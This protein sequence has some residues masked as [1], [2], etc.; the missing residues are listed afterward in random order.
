M[1]ESTMLRL[2]FVLVL[3]LAFAGCVQGTAPAPAA[4]APAATEAPAME[5]GGALV[6]WDQFYR[7]VESD[8]METLNAEF[9]ADHAG[10]TIDRDAKVL[11]DLTT[12]VQLALSEEDG[13]DVSQVNQGRGNM[14]PLVQGDLLLPVDEYADQYGWG[15]RLSESIQRRNRFTADGQ[16]FGEGNLYGVSPT[17]E[18]VGVYYN[19]D[20]F[21]EYGWSIPATF[22]EFQQLLADIAATGET[23]IAFGNLDGWPGI[24][25]FS[26]VEHVF[27]DPEWVDN[28]VY[29]LNDVSF[30]TDVNIQAAEIM[31]EWV[32]SGYFT[33]GF[34][35]IGYDDTVALF[36]SGDGVLMITGSWLSGELAD[37]D[38][39]FGFF[40]MPQETADAQQLA[41]GGVGIPFAIRRTTD[42]ADLAA[43][44]LDWM[45]S[46]RA[47]ELWAE[48]DFVPAMPLPEGAA[49]EEGSML[50]DT[51]A[52]WNRINADNGVGHYL[53]WATP[54]MYDTLVSELQKLFAA[55][56]SPE[57]FVANV[58]AD[59][60]EFLASQ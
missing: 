10:V 28:F 40:L 58:Q 16:T 48:A 51:I 49:V 1:R 25:E 27:A 3:A 23:P 18:V 5:E 19:Q 42:Q 12:T 22:D 36:K 4:E 24:H 57:E 17:A 54:T 38:F 2:T 9:E 35:G 21:E 20:K 34:E 56:T 43:E 8:V 41:V 7:G 15:E 55:Q 13:P 60:A 6:V 44:Y 53:D 50:A 46:P 47:A 32:D 14:G 33:D 59:Y 11:E 52:A 45:I 26:S 39:S 37:S 31:Q 30:E 29:G